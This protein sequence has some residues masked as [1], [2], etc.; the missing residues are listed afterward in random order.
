M[1]RGRCSNHQEATNQKLYFL[2]HPNTP[3][4]KGALGASSAMFATFCMSALWQFVL[5]V[6]VWKLEPYTEPSLRT[7]FHRNTYA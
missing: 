2:V 6:L 7:T 4:C 3:G 1:L 5:S